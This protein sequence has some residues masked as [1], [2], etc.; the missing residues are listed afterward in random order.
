MKNS[1]SM[2]I[3]MLTL[4]VSFAQI[5][6]TRVATK[7]DANVD[8]KSETKT[9]ITKESCFCCGEFYSLP[10]PVISGPKEIACGTQAVFTSKPCEGATSVWS[11]SPAI[12]GSTQ[13]PSSFTVPSNA[14]AGTYTLSYQVACNRERF[15][16]TQMQF[17]IVSV[18]NCKPD[19]LVTVTQLS[20]GMLTIATNPLMQT[21]GQEHWWGIQYNGTYPNCNPQAPIP[22]TSMNASGCFGGYVNSSGALSPF[23]GSGITIV[24]GYGITYSGFPNNSC[25]KITHYVKCCGQLIRQTAYFS[26]GTSNARMASSDKPIEIKPQIIMS[27]V[28]IV[29]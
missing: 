16:S 25:F 14:P 23:M 9:N 13:T 7:I 20:N 21:P 10:K 5:R 24:N 26:V 2:I 19:F 1:I 28:E 29:K 3:L 4:N 27:E 22:F 12:A 17:T 11:V 18:P 15:V 8:L 6:A